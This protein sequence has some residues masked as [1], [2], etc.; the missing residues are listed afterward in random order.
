MAKKSE[1]LRSIASRSKTQASGSWSA[2]I[3]VHKVWGFESQETDVAPLSRD[4]EK[5][6]SSIIE[7]F[8]LQKLRIALQV[9]FCF[10]INVPLSNLG[11]DSLKVIEFSYQWFVFS[12]A[13]C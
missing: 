12:L 3:R 7:G 11:P 4:F 5:Y 13:Q 2:L 10:C 9:L 8:I 6:R 1:S